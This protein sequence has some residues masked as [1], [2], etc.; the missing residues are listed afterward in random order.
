M[1]KKY[2]G[3][4][5]VEM[6]I[7]MG[8]IILLMGL[9][10]G[11]GRLALNNAANIAAKGA[12]KQLYEAG[13]AY[14]T[15]NGKFPTQNNPKTMLSATGELTPYSESFDGGNDTTFYYFV[16]STQQK[17][18]FCVDLAANLL[19]VKDVYCEGNG[20]GTLPSGAGNA[21]ASSNVVNG[22]A[23]GIRIQTNPLANENSKWTK[24]AWG[25]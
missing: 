16:D 2:Q 7:V 11:G 13:L 10:I 15:A 12:T 19:N 3:F 14:Y 6:L 23:A 22:T 8:I 4:T 17:A 21:A 9:G 5:L 1:S 20:F 25:L 18:L 24:K